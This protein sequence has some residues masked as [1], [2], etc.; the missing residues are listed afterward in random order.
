MESERIE[1]L[2]K[3]IEELE[4]E[5]D[6]Q[7]AQKLSKAVIVS[8][9]P[10]Y[11]VKIEEKYSESNLTGKYKQFDLKK[12]VNGANEKRNRDQKLEYWYAFYGKLK[13]ILGDQYGQGFWMELCYLIEKIIDYYENDVIT[14]ILKE[15]KY[16]D[17]GGAPNYYNKAQ[18]IAHWERLK[19]TTNRMAVYGLIADEI[20]IEHHVSDRT[21][22]IQQIIKEYER[23]K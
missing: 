8:P 21:K 18:I 22:R 12:A 7:R 14:Y 15:G 20:G 1:K 2:E 6:K 3:R 13:A 17:N 10:L 4:S 19:D 16:I 11:R 23:G 5:R 9:D